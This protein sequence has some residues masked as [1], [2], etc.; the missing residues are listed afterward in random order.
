MTP[1]AIP[2]GCFAEAAS[3][4]KK[5]GGFEIRTGGRVF[6]SPPFPVVLFA[7]SRKKDG[8]GLSRVLRKTWRAPRPGASEAGVSEGS[9][10]SPCE[11]RAWEAIRVAFESRQV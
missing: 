7:P 4:H 11:G 6:F 8:G 9:L 2:I 3:A 10:Q 5:V 1:R